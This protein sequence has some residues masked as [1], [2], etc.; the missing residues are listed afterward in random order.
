MHDI[1]YECVRS[2]DRRLV[3]SGMNAVKFYD[4]QPTSISATSTTRR[5]PTLLDGLLHGCRLD[6]ALSPEL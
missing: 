1:E 4:S 5:I 6:S 2:E 3:V